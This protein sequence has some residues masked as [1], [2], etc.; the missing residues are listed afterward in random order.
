MK[1]NV[2]RFHLSL[3]SPHT[4]ISMAL[5]PYRAS[6]SLIVI[7]L[8]SRFLCKQLHISGMSGLA[9]K[10]VLDVRT[11]VLTLI[12]AQDIWDSA[13]QLQAPNR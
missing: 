5:W 11:L 6:V 13:S 7:C 2:N 9:V 10:I 4:Q 1:M 12:P 8:R 3:H